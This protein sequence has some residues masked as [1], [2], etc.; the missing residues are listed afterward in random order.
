MVSLEV[1]SKRPSRRPKKGLPRGGLSFLITDL[2]FNSAGLRGAPQFTYT[3]VVGRS[4]E[5]PLV[6]HL[7]R[8][9]WLEERVVFR[10]PGPTAT[11]CTKNEITPSNKARKPPTPTEPITPATPARPKRKR[12]RRHPHP[13]SGTSLRLA[14]RSPS[15]ARSTSPTHHTRGAAIVRRRAQGRW[16]AVPR[17][18]SH[19]PVVSAG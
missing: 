18:C 1:E 16:P 2:A 6:R 10:R 19:R 11:N 17:G 3:S 7:A 15:P 5:P 4:H 13:G 12:S 14:F 8:R 9:K